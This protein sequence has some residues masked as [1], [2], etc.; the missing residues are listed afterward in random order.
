MRTDR[1]GPVSLKASPADGVV[2]K[3]ANKLGLA[4]RAEAERV[5]RL[6]S[7]PGAPLRKARAMA[8]LQCV[9]AYDGA[10]PQ[11]YWHDVGKQMAMSA[12]AIECAANDLCQCGIAT[13]SAWGCGVTLRLFPNSLL[14]RSADDGR[15]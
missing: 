3:A 2:N 5:K 10:L 4:T 13:L 6:R 9:E 11:H 14:A 12:K 8:L 15:Q 1:D 7:L